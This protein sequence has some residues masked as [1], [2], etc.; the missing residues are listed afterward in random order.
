[1]AGRQRVLHAACRS[2]GDS[3]EGVRGGPAAPAAVVRGRAASPRR[4]STAY[5]AH[6]F[7]G[8]GSVAGGRA[9]AAAAGAR[10]DW[11]RSA[12]GAG[13]SE[14]ERGGR[15]FRG[16]TDEPIAGGTD[17]RARLAAGPLPRLLHPLAPT[18][19]LRCLLCMAQTFLPGRN[20]LSQGARTRAFFSAS[21]ER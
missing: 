21:S 3:A 20:T 14:R 1:M 17:T 4:C 10:R 2:R 13:R 9:A 5:F 15:E 8:R 18:P 6:E 11:S 12:L 16:G 7:R 19:S